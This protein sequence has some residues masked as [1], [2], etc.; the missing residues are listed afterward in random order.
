MSISILTQNTRGLRTKVNEFFSNLCNLTADFVCITETWLNDEF[1]SSEY[2]LDNFK[3]YRRDRNYT[4]TQTSRGG[5]VWLFHKSNIDSIRRYDLESKIDFVED[6]WIQVK[7]S[8][9][10]RFLYICVVYITPKSG[11]NNHLYVAFSNKVKDN[12]ALIGP[13]DRVLI[14]GDFN[15]SKIDWSYTSN[16]V[17]IP[18][19]NESCL[20]SLEVL[21]MINFGNFNQFNSV[22]NFQN[23]ILDLV[24]YTDPARVIKVSKSLDNLVVPDMYHPTLEITIDIH[25]SYLPT[26]NHRKYN[27]RKSN[28]DLICQELSITDWSFINFMPL[29]LAIKQFYNILNEI[30]HRHTPLYGAKS[31]FPFWYDKSLRD[32][33]AKKERARKKFKKNNNI[34]DRISYCELRAL[35]KNMIVICYN[36]YL[37]S[38]Q[39][40]I[41]KNIKL[42]WAYAK[43]KKQTNSYPSQFSNG[44]LTAS[45][46]KEICDLFAEF[47]KSTYTHHSSNRSFSI[48]QTVNP[49][50]ESQITISVEDVEK[51]IKSL[52]LNK[53]GGPDAIPNIFFRQ[54]L[55]Q[56]SKPL[57]DIFN[58]SLQT[59][60]YPTDFKTSFITPIH[61]KGDESS[62]SNY[63]QV[64]L[65]NVISIIFEKVIYSHLLPLIGDK[66]THK[67]H[68]FVRGRS[69]N[70]NLTEYVSY[71]SNALDEKNE[72]HVMYADFSKAFD[73]VDHSILLFKLQ[74]MGLDSSLLKW[75]HSYLSHRIV[76]VSFNGERSFQFSPASGVP[77]G[78][79][80]GPLLFNIFINDLSTILQCSFLL[81][82]DD[83]KI[84][85]KIRSHYDIT[86]LQ[87]DIDKLF[88]WSVINNLE[89]NINKCH[90]MVFS[91]KQIPSKANYSINN[92]QLGEV[93]TFKDLG[94]TFDSKLKFDKHIESIVMTSYKMLGFIMR[95]TS[96]FHEYSCIQYLYNALVRSRLEYNTVVWNPHDQKYKLKIEEVQRKYTRILFFKLNHQQ[97]PYNQRLKTLNLTE[98]EG[99][100][101][102]FD[103]CFL[104]NLIHDENTL[105]ESRPQFRIN[106]YSTRSNNIFNTL[107]NSTNYGIHTNPSVRAQLLFDRKFSEIDI[108]GVSKNILKNKVK[109]LIKS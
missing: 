12:V 89:L 73:T 66:I 19:L 97:Q 25:V 7:L 77:Q 70:S 102:Y 80:L 96:G 4:S 55:K 52:D 91:N 81:F 50:T 35:S 82:A 13:N 65:S 23:K 75:F 26:F 39:V 67:Q 51:I 105:T 71:I 94:V 42:F 28:Y 109:E 57:V 1:Q 83:L 47:F 53:N 99:R 72:V 44:S 63:R 38:L 3:S 68:G 87:R 18:T 27:F 90:T 24:L 88:E 43:S 20:N 5:G 107:P 86:L 98:L 46:P 32:L 11:N 17:M 106:H 40:N 78:S 33:I 41:K 49:S 54:T 100:R 59:S 108:M 37:T 58:R 104:H 84:F 101:E 21:D 36:K 48:S 45:T 79:V 76:F 56:I 9:S 62:V 29:N 103:M 34:R 15:V 64:C 30:I 10:N 95:I 31:K 16:G 22:V 6:V 8:S 85:I 60:I 69:T 74:S 92:I 2:L 61:K 14:V 93:A